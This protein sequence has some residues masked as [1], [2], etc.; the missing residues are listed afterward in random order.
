MSVPAVQ[1]HSRIVDMVHP[2]QRSS[3][4]VTPVVV[5][6]NFAGFSTSLKPS[7]H[8]TSRLSGV[9]CSTTAEES[10]S[11]ELLDWAWATGTVIMLAH[12]SRPVRRRAG[13]MGIP[14]VAG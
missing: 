9:G 8:S 2:F 12:S 4:E 6:V 1:V 14:Q 10:G 13:R 7:N 5:E 3:P 11:E